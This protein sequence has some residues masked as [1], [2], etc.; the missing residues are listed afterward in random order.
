MQQAVLGLILFIF[1]V[2]LGLAHATQIDQLIKIPETKVI[3]EHN[4]G[5]TAIQL[6]EEHGSGAYYD[7]TTQSLYTISDHGPNIKCKYTRAFFGASDFCT[8]GRIVL[9]PNFQPTIF[10]WKYNH[11]LHEFS[12]EKKIP[13]TTQYG[14]N[15]LGLPTPGTKSK[16][17]ID[18]KR[19]PIP[20]STKGIDP[21]SIIKLNNGSFYLSEEHGPSLLHLDKDGRILTRYVPA[22]ST[23][24]LEDDEIPVVGLLPGIL[25]KRY[26]GRGLEG[27]AVSPNNK[28]LFFI[29]QSPLANPNKKAYKRSRWVRLFKARLNKNGSIQQV[30]NEYVYPL[31][32]P[33]MFTSKD[34]I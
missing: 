27:I 29:Q 13:I 14:T 20:K 4:N 25:K 3:I 9:N 21:E 34:G 16:N 10:Q 24:F 23:N 8:K 5:R 12:L 31:D 17:L 32:T 15:V 30:V 28:W 19:R 18:I 26:S 2:H 22:G 1:V 6:F 11:A 7:F 33:T